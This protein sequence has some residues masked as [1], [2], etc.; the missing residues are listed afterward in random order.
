MTLNNEVHYIDRLRNYVVLKYTSLDSQ[1]LL[2]C[3]DLN[4]ILL[5][6]FQPKSKFYSNLVL[7]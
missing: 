6:I 5:T 1:M 7:L 2:T 3:H 4:L